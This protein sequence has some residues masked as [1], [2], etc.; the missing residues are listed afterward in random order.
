MPAELSLSLPLI[1]GFVLVFTRIAGIFTF[2]P[3]P[4]LKTGPDAPRLVFCL[5][6]TGV[7]FPLWPRP[8][9]APNQIGLF[10]LWMFGEFAFGL[11]IGTTLA[12]VLESFEVAAQLAGMQAGYAY[13]STIDP[14]TQADSSVLYVFVQLFSVVLFFAL[15]LDRRVI[16]IIGVSL[17][18]APPGSWQMG[19]AFG[20]AVARMGATMFSTGLQLA[21]PVLAF[22]LTVDVGFGIA[23][24]MSPQIQLLSMA[25]PVK[26]LGGLILFAFVLGMAPQVLNSRASVALDFLKGL[27]AH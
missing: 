27:V 18:T 11:A 24:R 26:M 21:M 4:G 19:P 20:H 16:E 3:L 12:F 13:A 22:L 9:I 7:L 17:R 10:T 23:G 14:T 25:F 6:L 8:P 1:A 5:L 15:G 2:L